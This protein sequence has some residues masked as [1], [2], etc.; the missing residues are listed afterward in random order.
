MYTIIARIADINVQFKTRYYK[1]PSMCKGYIIDD[2]EPDLTIEVTSEQI[3]HEELITPYENKTLPSV[4]EA[5]SAYRQFCHQLWKFDALILHSVA[6][7]VDNIGIAFAA[8]SG[9]GKTTHTRLWHELLG[10]KMSII[11]GDKPIIKFIDGIPFAYGTPWKGKESFGMNASVQLSNICFIERD[12]KN[13]VRRLKKED[14]INRIFN[15]ILLPSDPVGSFKTLH[16]I[17]NLLDKCNLWVI[18]CNTDIEAAEI[19]YS[20]IVLNEGE[21]L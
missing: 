9:T 4:Y 16:M 21:K 10:E 19:A 15:Q 14:A 12:S 17:D 18:M 7:S 1:V 6:I 13:S 11:N 3:R 2:I 5:S 20:K 8:K